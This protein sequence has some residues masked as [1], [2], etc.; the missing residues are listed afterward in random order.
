M[1]LT[2]FWIRHGLSCAN[3]HTYFHALKFDPQ[4]TFDGIECSESAKNYIPKN[5]DFVFASGLKRAIETALSM[6][7]S[8]LK[9]NQ[10]IVSVPFI[11]EQGFGYDNMI[12]KT[13]VL[14][15]YFKPIMDKLD[16]RIHKISKDM[17]K[18][19]LKEFFRFLMLFLTLKSK[20]LNK[21][22]FRIAIV[23]HSHFMK[24][25]NIC[26]FHKG[27]ALKPKNNSIY[28]ID[29]NINSIADIP[30]LYKNHS[31]KNITREIFAGCDFSSK[32]N[33][34]LSCNRST[35]K[36]TPRENYLNYYR[37][38]RK[39]SKKYSNFSESK[40]LLTLK[41]FNKIGGKKNRSAKYI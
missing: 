3:I 36:K 7:G 39:S 27:K 16:L 19:D 37:C 15:N 21:T 12:S 34:V 4:L 20:E 28:K 17:N 23:T 35:C 38:S 26:K 29:Y 2:I 24:H 31:K 6:F 32:D 5:L 33:K 11:S 18:A 41:N 40:K 25:N 8:S 13:Q 10:K 14:E 9:K 30:L 1:K 22:N